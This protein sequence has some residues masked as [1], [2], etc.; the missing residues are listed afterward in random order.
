MKKIITIVAL[1][2]ATSAFANGDATAALAKEEAL[3]ASQMPL[4]QAPA[5]RHAPELQAKV[6]ITK[7]QWRREQAARILAKFKEQQPV[8]AHQHHHD[9]S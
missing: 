3:K 6:N 7:A 4:L 8:R 9:E 2:M 1:M 5:I